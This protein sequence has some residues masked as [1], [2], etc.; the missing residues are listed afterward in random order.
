MAKIFA[1]E[2]RA[3]AETACQL[4][5]LGLE[6]AVAVG[7]A[8]F[9][10]GGRQ[11]VEIA[12]ARQFHGLQI[13]LG[14]GAADDDCEMI[15]R[16]GGGAERAELLVDEPR[17]RFR[18]QHRLGLLIQKALVRRAAA[19]RDEQEFVLVA[20]LGVEVDLGRQIV[21]GI[22]LLVHRQGRH[23]A[24]AQMVLSV[25]PP[26]ALGQRRRVV[27]AGPYTLAFSAHHDRGAGVLAHRQ[28]L[29]GRDIRV[30]Q[31]VERNEAVVCRR[32]GVVENGSQLRQMPRAQQMLTIKEGLAR[33]QRQGLGR[34]LDHRL[35]IE[36]CR[37]D[38]VARQ[39][40]I[41]GVVM[42]Q[43][44]KFMELGVAHAELQRLSAGESSVRSAAGRPD[45]PAIG[46]PG[47]LQ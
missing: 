26:D 44:K 11:A 16:T 41:R 19:L 37:R 17:Q 3:N 32:L 13:H 18:I 1:A 15:W 9:V 12:A 27:A 21:A 10:A 29:A 43:R 14:R 5:H 36:Q 24:I 25:D 31:Q 8:V 39:L 40:A 2:L 35:S 46:S 34:D 20:G 47:P 45:R 7:L 42:A 22:D 6:I 30:L 28:D 33:Q 23:L 38:M 4:Q